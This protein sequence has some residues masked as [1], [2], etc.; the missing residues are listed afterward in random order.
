MAPNDRPPERNLE[1]DE[2]EFRPSSATTATAEEPKSGFRVLKFSGGEKMRA[3]TQPGG[4]MHQT[5]SPHVGA[6][7]LAR[8]NKQSPCKP[9]KTPP[10][11]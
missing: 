11:A 10:S 3:E 6:K 9:S 4:S 8:L 7:Q 1:F 5:T 2:V